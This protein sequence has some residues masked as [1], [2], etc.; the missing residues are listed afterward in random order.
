MQ[1]LC[2]LIE[3]K[4]EVVWNMEATL[5]M[6]NYIKFYLVKAIVKENGYKTSKIREDSP[7]ERQQQQKGDIKK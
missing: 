2:K 7:N 3:E 6:R 1:N 5:R 4:L